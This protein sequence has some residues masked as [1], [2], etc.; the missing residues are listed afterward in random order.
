MCRPTSVSSH[1][2]AAKS[3]L[4]VMSQPRQTL[5]PLAPRIFVAT[6]YSSY[7]LQIAPLIHWLSVWLPW[8]KL[9]II[10]HNMAAGIAGGNSRELTEQNLCDSQ[11]HICY[12]RLYIF[13]LSGWLTDDWHCILLFYCFAFRNMSMLSW[14]TMFSFKGLFKWY[15]FF[16]WVSSSSHWMEHE[17]TTSCQSW[18]TVESPVSFS[19]MWWCC[20]FFM[21]QSLFSCIW[22]K[23]SWWWI[24]FLSQMLNI[25]NLEPANHSTSKQNNKSD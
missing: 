19:K 24:R 10:I 18:N 25:L 15:V 5:L 22:I 2:R 7:I 12:S 6:L 14:K 21:Y 17:R 13:K 4:L 20:V 8:C 16:K 1:S 3:P 11:F 9:E 23:M